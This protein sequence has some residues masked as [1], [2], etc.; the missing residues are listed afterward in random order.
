MKTLSANLSL[1]ANN[2][3][4]IKLEKNKEVPYIY[5]NIIAYLKY[6]DIVKSYVLN[7]PYDEKTG[8][9]DCGESA[10]S[11]ED[12]KFIRLANGD[13]K[14]LWMREYIKFHND[15]VK[16]KGTDYCELEIPI[17]EILENTVVDLE[18]K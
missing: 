15:W 6:D 5:G 17:N 14:K 4:K 8:R 13:E 12:V 7:H 9:C 3:V 1:Y 18:M 16:A 2:F 11:P 10:F